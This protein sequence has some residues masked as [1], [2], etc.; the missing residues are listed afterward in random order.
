MSHKFAPIA[1]ALLA[2]AAALPA[3]DNPLSTETK[4]FYNSVKNNIIKAAEK[5]PAEQY[6]FKPVPEVRTFAGVLG[7]IADTQYL[8]CSAVKGEEKKSDVE[9]TA[10]TKAA[11]V[12][13]LKA[14]F[15]YC[16]DAYNTLTDADAAQKVKFFNGQRTKFGILNINNGHNNEHYGN[17]VTYMRIKGL[18][19]PSSEGR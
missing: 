14:A 18:V 13:A 11:A 6:A 10:T 17:L 4:G 9:K 2:C 5:M 15:A 12:E 3:Q 19:P 16:D 1:T 7:H 8:F